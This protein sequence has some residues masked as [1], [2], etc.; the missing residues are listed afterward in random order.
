M[1]LSLDLRKTGTEYVDILKKKSISL[2]IGRLETL[3]EEEEQI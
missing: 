3:K 1:S 2:H